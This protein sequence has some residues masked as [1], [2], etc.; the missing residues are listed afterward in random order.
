MARPDGPRTSGHRTIRLGVLLV[1]AVLLAMVAVRAHRADAAPEPPIIAAIG[2]ERP[3]LSPA[4]WDRMQA[5]VAADMERG[6]FPGAVLIVGSGP[7]VLA[8]SEHGRLEWVDRSAAV[9][10]VS[11][12]Y[13]LASLTKAVATSVAVWL[14]IEDGRMSL[15][16]PVQRYLPGFQGQ[17][18]ERVTIRHLLTH[19]SGLPPGTRL[20]GRTPEEVLT[21]IQ[22]TLIPVPPGTEVSYSDVGFAILWAAAERAAGEPL[23]TLLR[24][25]VWEPLGMESTR[26]RPGRDCEECAPTLHLEQP[27]RVPYRGEPADH[28]ARRLGG[29]AG[30][31]GLFSTAADLARFAG[32]IAGGG[33][34]DGVRVLSEE[35]VAALLTQADGAGNR[36]SGWEAYCPD[37]ERRPGAA[38][39][40][41]LAFGHTG[42]T[43]TSMYVDPRTGR[44]MVLLTN[45]TYLPRAPSRIAELRA[46][47]WHTLAE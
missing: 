40:R 29:I 21:R 22:R 14:L 34:I 3:T 23:P 6:A 33:A 38:C 15:D 36:T 5:R 17:Y 4:A 12:L 18:K 19:T 43:G 37:E 42:F 20:N 28:T 16:D 46:E 30:N 2:A 13:D 7:D 44:W 24:R 32:M 31:A 35:S 27:P 26:F 25:R 9:S 11:T 41:P 10:A 39:A 47:L 1:A 8:V 45:R